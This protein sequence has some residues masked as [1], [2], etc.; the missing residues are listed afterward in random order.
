M[1]TKKSL[2]QMTILLAALVCCNGCVSAWQQ[3]RENR[4]M[5]SSEH[6]FNPQAVYKTPPGGLVVKNLLYQAG[7]EWKHTGALR[8]PEGC[9]IIWDF[10]FVGGDELKH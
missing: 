3:M 7:R 2:L 6:I 5:R 1:R 8:L 9:V 10:E 4:M